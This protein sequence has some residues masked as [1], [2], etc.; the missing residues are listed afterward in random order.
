MWP[1]KVVV[2]SPFGGKYLSF[3]DVVEV[4]HVQKRI[5]ESAVEASHISGLPLIGCQY[6][7]P[8]FSRGVEAVPD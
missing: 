4:F 2:G 5:P 8:W 6:S 1:V 7:I 3:N